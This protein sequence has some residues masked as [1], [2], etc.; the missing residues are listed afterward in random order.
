MRSVIATELNAPQ[1]LSAASGVPAGDFNVPLQ[2]DSRSARLLVDTHGP[3]GRF[4]SD[5]VAHNASTESLV[6][7]WRY[8]FANEDAVVSTMTSAVV[9]STPVLAGTLTSVKIPKGAFF[10]C[11]ITSITLTSGSVTLF[12]Q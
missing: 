2:L 10:P 6:G 12:E 3:R 11:V 7:Y 1:G 9:G 4:V 8:I 5:T